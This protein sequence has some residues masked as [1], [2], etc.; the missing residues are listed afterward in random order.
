[1][2]SAVLIT[3]NEAR[4]ISDCIRSLSTVTDDI[5]IVD[6]ESTDD[7]VACA[8]SLGA[9]CIVKPWEGYGAAR[10]EGAQMAQ[11]DWILS[12]DA[13][14]RVDEHLRQAIEAETY[15][16]GIIYKIKRINYLAG[17]PIQFGFLSPEFKEKIY[18]KKEAHW[19][20]AVVHERLLTSGQKKL[21]SVRLAGSLHHYAYDDVSNL[22]NKLMSYASLYSNDE[23][24]AQASFIKRSC[25]PIFHF[26]KSYFFKLGILEGSQGWHLAKAGYKYTRSKYAKN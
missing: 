21:T 3:K 25:S 17:R 7:T 6:A 2:I 4:N 5:I 16:S 9:R 23:S 19:D 10:N 24:K 1:M 18:H 14:E 15:K 22:E 11:W 12:I 20:S 26:I 8:K 13:D